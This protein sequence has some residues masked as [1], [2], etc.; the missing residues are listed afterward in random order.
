M[1]FPLPNPGH[2]ARDCPKGRTPAIH[3]TDAIPKTPDA[4][5][6][7]Q[8][9]PTKTQQITAIVASMDEEERGSN[10]DSCNMDFPNAEL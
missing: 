6:Q 5:V 4:P 3:A 1:M 9:A 2:L 7:Q 8:P 10:L